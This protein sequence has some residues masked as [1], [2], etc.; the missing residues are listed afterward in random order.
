MTP[1]PEEL[2]AVLSSAEAA[3]V[4]NIEYVK[5][6]MGD[7]DQPTLQVPQ[8]SML[9]TLQ[10]EAHEGRPVAVEFHGGWSGLETPVLIDHLLT[11]RWP[12]I[13]HVLPMYYPYTA[14]TVYRLT[15]Y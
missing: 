3:T 9:L 1:I 10:L 5:A 13:D 2:L 12:S 11:N 14:H 6:R 15:I 7:P 8:T 4:T